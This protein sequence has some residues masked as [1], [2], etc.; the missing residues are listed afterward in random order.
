MKTKEN[1]TGLNI[2]IVVDYLQKCTAVGRIRVNTAFI[3]KHR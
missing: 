1:L 3:I 2:M